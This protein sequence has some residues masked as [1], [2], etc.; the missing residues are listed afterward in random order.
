MIANKMDASQETYFFFFFFAKYNTGLPPDYPMVCTY[1][2][3]ILDSG[4]R[5]LDSRNTVWDSQIIILLVL[6]DSQNCKGNY[7]LVDL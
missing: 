4:L 3:I 2:R 7:I 6:K 1:N 5:V